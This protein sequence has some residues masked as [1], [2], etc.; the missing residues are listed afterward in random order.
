MRKIMKT[1][2]YTLLLLT[3]LVQ[4][5]LAG[6]AQ[7]NNVAQPGTATAGPAAIIPLDRL[8]VVTGSAKRAVGITLTTTAAA[9]TD[10]FTNFTDFS[11]D[12]KY[13]TVASGKTFQTLSVC[14]RTASTV[15]TGCQI[16]TSDI[17]PAGGTTVAGINSVYSSGSANV[18][19]FF[20][21]NTA[22]VEECSHFYSVITA[23]KCISAQCGAQSAGGIRLH[24][25][26]E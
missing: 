22:G 6:N 19:N 21:S 8:T 25:I 1:F 26:Y 2:T 15:G 18:Y 10:F 4:A 16:V 13:F 14:M 20:P 9:G 3:C 5:A 12:R 24:G 7:V 23:G 11:N 17:C